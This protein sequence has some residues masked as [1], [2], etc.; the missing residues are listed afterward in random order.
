MRQTQANATKRRRVSRNAAMASPGEE[1]SESDAWRIRDDSYKFER[2]Y[3]NLPFPGPDC[4]PAS[5]LFIP[6]VIPGP[7]LTV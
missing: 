4:R 5:C 2:S 3:F 6:L 1:E 7:F